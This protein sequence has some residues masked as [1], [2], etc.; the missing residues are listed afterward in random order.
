MSEGKRVDIE[1]YLTKF[2][3]EP[4]ELAR[5]L[6]QVILDTLPELDEV[7]KWGHLVY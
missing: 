5:N 3:P 7:V 2:E 6:R 1:D 4:S